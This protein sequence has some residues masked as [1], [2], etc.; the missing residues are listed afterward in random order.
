M[1]RGVLFNLPMRMTTR[2]TTRTTP[3]AAD[4]GSLD[5]RHSETPPDHA[6]PG[7]FS[8][9]VGGGHQQMIGKTYRLKGCVPMKLRSLSGRLL[10]RRSCDVC[11]AFF[12]RSPRAVNPNGIN[13]SRFS[14]RG[15]LVKFRNSEY[16]A[17]IPEKK[18][19]RTLGPL[20]SQLFTPLE[21]RKILI[22][23]AERYQ[24]PG[25]SGAT[26]EG[27]TATQIVF[28]GQLPLGGIVGGNIDRE[29]LV[30]Q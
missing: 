30:R 5:A 9:V 22:C 8:C 25:V 24:L 29:A 13:G 6:G 17:I 4:G 10:H 18:K 7:A 16:G 11:S 23:R 3:A 19:R 27:Q 26:H 1:S 14:N 28:A 12:S 15:E 21:F 20:F 2:T